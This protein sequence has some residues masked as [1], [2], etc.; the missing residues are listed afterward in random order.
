V[1]ETRD[2]GFIFFAMAIGMAMGT[3]FYLLGIM[4]T[5]II[6]IVILIMNRFDWYARRVKSQVLKIQI[7]MNTDFEHL[8]DDIFVK[9]T[10]SSNLMSI[11][12]VRGGALTELVYSVTTDPNMN[13]QEFIAKLRI[14]TGGQ[15]VSLITGYNATDL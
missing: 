15:K 11:D 1:K 14:L 3:K 10:E 12:T 9:Y 13:K 6:S 8:F 4:G 2:V 7:D 5:A